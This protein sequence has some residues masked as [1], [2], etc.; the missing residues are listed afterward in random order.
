LWCEVEVRR[1]GDSRTAVVNI[2]VTV[3][4]RAVVAIRTRLRAPVAGASIVHLAVTVVVY[5]VRALRPGFG[6]DRVRATA[7]NIEASEPD[8]WFPLVVASGGARRLLENEDCNES[9]TRL[10]PWLARVAVLRFVNSGGN[11]GNYII[12][13]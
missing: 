7:F 10:N 11:F 4:I 1:F 13:I 2:A 12:E 9:W 6:T 5:V 8:D 3:V